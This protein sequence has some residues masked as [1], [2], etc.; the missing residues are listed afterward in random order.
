MTLPDK[1]RIGAIDYTVSEE[2]ELKNGEDR[3]FGFISYQYGTIKVEADTTPRMKQIAVWHEVLHGLFM[4][5]GM[6]NMDM[7]ENI[8]V[9]L[10]HALVG[11]I[12]EN[13]A[14]A[15]F[16]LEDEIVIEKEQS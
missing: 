6:H 5:A 3:C 1:L 11:L 12:R 15:A 14:L 9:A 16:T 2:P 7:E 10:S 13:P 4:H 8:V